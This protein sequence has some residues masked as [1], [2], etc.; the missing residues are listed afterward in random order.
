MLK[1]K[2][3][4]IACV[5]MGSWSSL[6]THDPD[7]MEPG[8]CFYHGFELSRRYR[9][10]DAIKRPPISVVIPNRSGGNFFFCADAHPESNWKDHWD[11][12]IKGPLRTGELPPLSVN[13]SIDFKGWYHGYLTDG[14]LT[15]DWGW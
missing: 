15:K 10:F 3:G 2:K 12:T 1:L 8:W 5:W 6:P 11:V 14:I 4:D 7:E 13:P 9:L